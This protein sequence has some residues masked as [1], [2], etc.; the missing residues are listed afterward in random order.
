MKIFDNILRLS[1][2]VAVIFSVSCSCDKDSSTLPPPSTGVIPG[3]GDMTK[4]YEYV[5]SNQ[6]SYI[7]SLQMASG[8]IKDRPSEDSKITPYFAHFAVLALLAE[9]DETNVGAVKK[10]VEWYFGKLNSEK[11]QF[12]DDEIQGSVYDYYA[13]DERTEGKYDSVDSYAATFLEILMSLAKTSDT[14][15][16]WL[17]QYKDKVS[18]VARAMLKT[19]DAEINI[20]PGGNQND[21][22]SVAHY[23]YTIKYLMDNTEVNMGLK[24]C[25]WLRD[26]GLLEVEP[27]LEL[28]LEKNTAGIESLYNASNGNYDFAKGNDSDWNTFYPGATAQL[29]PFIFGVL[30]PMATRSLQLYDKF[31]EMYPEWET[32]KTYDAYPWTMIVH[33]AAVMND[34]ERVNAYVNHIYGMNIK[35]EQKKNWYS[36]EAGSLVLAIEKMRKTLNSTTN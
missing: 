7:R 18:L 3:K 21:Y 20:I 25:I 33:A 27:D 30:S 2:A 11:T 29:Y 12:H 24:A 10:Y 28:I 31:N 36:A 23:R 35:N 14:A 4:V 15:K 17:M 5:I 22:L 34:A 9:P 8:A 16:D 6:L 13:P 32:G 19:V 26:N 1:F